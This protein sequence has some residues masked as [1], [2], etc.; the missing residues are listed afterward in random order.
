MM[1]KIQL[2]ILKIEFL[3][4]FFIQNLGLASIRPLHKIT[5][6]KLTEL[7]IVKNFIKLS[8]TILRVGSE[9]KSN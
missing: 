1:L 6:Q 2:Y 8:S 3:I 7:K 4:I 9:Q 5:K